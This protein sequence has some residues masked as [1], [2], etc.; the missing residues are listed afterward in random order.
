[1][2]SI[3]VILYM[4]YKVTF[5]LDESNLWIERHLRKFIFKCKKR[6]IFKIS[7]DPKKI[8]KQDIVFP[9]SYTKILSKE[10]LNKNRL[11]LVVHES[12]LPND[13]GYAPVQNQILKNKNKI[14][15]T[16]FK[17]VSKVDA[18]PVY[19][20]DSF[21]LSGKELSYEIRSKQAQA[22]LKLI[23]R[24]LNNFPKVKSFKQKGKGNFNKR[25]KPEDNKLNINK[26]IKSQFNLLR[27]SDNDL[28]PSF[29]NHRNQK[30]I[31]KIYKQ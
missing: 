7:K 11:T 26:T 16:L 25:R 29:F 14:H 18:G 9:L 5:L 19:F 12:K 20:R 6:Y 22:K 10:F 3:L 21:K 1:M 13:K 28:Y 8:K 27:I 23:N 31:I 17:A 24:F 30:Y 4:K 2:L 15:I